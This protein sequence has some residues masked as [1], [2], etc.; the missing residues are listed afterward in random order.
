MDAEHVINNLKERNLVI[1]PEKIEEYEEEVS[2]RQTT[3]PSKEYWHGK[4]VFITGINGFAGSHLA[5]ALIGIGAEVHGLV[6]RQSVPIHSNLKG[7]K[8]KLILHTG[9]LLSEKKI[10]EIIHEVSP[11]VIFHLAAE[12]FVPTSFREPGLVVN[13]NLGGTINVLEAC[14]G[15]KDLEAVHLAGS[16]EQYGFVK[17]E[18]CPITEETE[19]KPM[20]V[21]AITKIGLELAGK[22]YHRTYN[23]PAVITRGFNHTGPRRGQEFVTSVVAR[24][25]AKAL[26]R[27]EKIFRIG[28]MDSFRDFTDVRDMV[29]GYML[30]VEKGK[31]GEAYALCSGKT[32]RIKDFVELAMKLH[33]VEMR[34]EVDPKR[35]RASDVPILLGDYSKAKREF[36]W[37]PVIPLTQTIKDMVEWFKDNQDF[38]DV[39]HH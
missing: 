18:D 1:L 39:E 14:R 32:I 12:S 27:G 17:P 31:R 13:T 29:K 24:Q 2:K 15:L 26:L 3:V 6:R 36:G 9:N 34:I 37:E 5:E 33:G 22:H 38:L 20:S 10:K 8:H 23:I 16:S 7:F 28:N 25:V 21:Y 4:K 19:L 11:Q 30:A 35:I